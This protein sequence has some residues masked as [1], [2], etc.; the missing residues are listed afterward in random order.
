M[1]VFYIH[2]QVFDIYRQ[3]F[4]IYRQVFYI[5]RQAFHN[6]KQVFNICRNDFDIYKHILGLSVWLGVCLFLW[7]PPAFGFFDG[8]ALG[9]PASCVVGFGGGGGVAARCGVVG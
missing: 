8:L 3:V 4:Y 2:R 6:H 1:Q 7:A 5:Y 9:E